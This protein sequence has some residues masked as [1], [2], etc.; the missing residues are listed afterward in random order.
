MN[1]YTTSIALLC[2]YNTPVLQYKLMV[3]FMYSTKCFIPFCDSVLQ[4]CLSNPQQSN[5]IEKY[6]EYAI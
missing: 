5:G 6:A 3:Y 2:Y 1:I 4:R